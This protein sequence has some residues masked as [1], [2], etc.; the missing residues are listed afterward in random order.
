MSNLLRL[1]DQWIGRPLLLDPGKAEIAMRA[2]E[3]RIGFDMS[4]ADWIEPEANRFVGSYRREARP[5]GL[6]RASNGVGILT[7]DG[8]LVNRG[9]YLGASSGLVSY[10]GIGAQ[11]MDVAADH[12]IRALV[13]DMNSPG[14]HASGLPDLASRVRRVAEQKPIAIVVNDIAASA[15]YGI[16]SQAHEIIVSPSSIVGSIG[17]ILLHL[18]ASQ[19]LEKDGLKPTLF[20]AGARKADGH[21]AIPLSES[22]AK[23]IQT[24]IEKTYEGFLD[25]V[26]MGRGSRLPREAARSTEAGIFI[27]EDAVKAGLADRVGT[28][29]ETISRLARGEGRLRVISTFPGATMNTIDPNAPTHAPAAPQSAPPPAPA[30]ASAPAMDAAAATKRIQ[31]I[32]DCEEAKTRP[33]LAKHLA[34]NTSMSA[35]DAVATLKVSPSE[36]TAGG[37]LD[38]KRDQTNL[39]LPTPP[40]N[41]DN[42]W[43]DVIT[44]INRM[45]GF[46]N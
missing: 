31:T 41:A 22:A 38:R 6:V 25:V 29:E 44:G 37:Y 24:M 13:I 33:T 18:D 10:E 7:I 21:P 4:E 15:A 14:G 27:G 28:L 39:G 46:Q 9:A 20:Y 2:L 19:K 26:S 42:G 3:G 40:A 30:V 23:S 8:A 35:D 1:L 12:E 36:A 45:N 34:F 16:A 11:L 43:G 32:I 17:V 5:S